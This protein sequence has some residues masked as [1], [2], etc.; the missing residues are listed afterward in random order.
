MVTVLLSGGLGNQM[1]QY[2][3]ARALANR[4]H[5]T[6]LIDTYAL[7]KKT[8]T[9]IRNYQLDVFQFKAKR[10]SSLKNKLFVKARPFIQG[11]RAFFA[12]SG[13]FSDYW[14]IKYDP[15]FES[16]KGNITLSGYF[17]NEK[18][19]C[20]SA[21]EVRTDF[22]FKEPLSGKNLELSDK[23]ICTESVSIHIRRGDYLLDKNAVNNFVTCP[24]EYYQSAIEYIMSKT[25]NPF[26]YIFSDDIDWVRENIVFPD[27]RV[28]YVDWNRGAD[29]YRDMQ[30]MS[31][32]T[33]NVI[34]NSSFSWWAAWLNTNSNKI[35]IAPQKW[36]RNEEKNALLDDFYPYGWIKV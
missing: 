2:A 24:K 23:L 33:H 13:F 10:V 8:D 1:F 26:F 22:I 36:F 3:A 31:L 32:C 18:Y 15:D 27:D 30:L 4:L 11:H 7:E 14:A 34:A 5:T 20:D 25:V 16:L 28:E 17:Q 21:T 19:F 12:R 29:S 9:T 35:V 6:V